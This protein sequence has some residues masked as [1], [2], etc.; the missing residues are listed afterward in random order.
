MHASTP[1]PAGHG[2]HLHTQGGAELRKGGSLQQ[3]CPPSYAH[4]A[5]SQLRTHHPTLKEPCND[6]VGQPNSADHITKENMFKN[7]PLRQN[8]NQ[9]LLFRSRNLWGAHSTIRRHRHTGVAHLPERRGKDK[10]PSILKT[11]PFDS[12]AFTEIEATCKRVLTWLAR[13]RTPCERRVCAGA[14]VST[15]GRG[16]V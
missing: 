3:L 8:T 16:P 4:L 5:E 11:I 12:N 7:Y 14:K 9:G 2:T 13:D 1:A 10:T 15:A 6:W